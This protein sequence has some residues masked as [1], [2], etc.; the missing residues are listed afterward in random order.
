MTICAIKKRRAS[1]RND[2]NIDYQ[3]IVKRGSKIM[4]M[5][6]VIADKG[7]KNEKPF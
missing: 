7:Y 5:S 1:T 4:P 3:P 2:N 6:L